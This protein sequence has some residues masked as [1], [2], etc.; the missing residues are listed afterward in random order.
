V[1]DAERDYYTLWDDYINQLIAT[2]RAEAEIRTFFLGDGLDQ[3]PEPTPQ[4]HR[5]ATPKPR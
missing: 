5:D 1:L 3:P 2:R 4:G